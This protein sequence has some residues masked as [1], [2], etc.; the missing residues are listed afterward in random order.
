MICTNKEAQ[1]SLE[2]ENEQLKKRVDKLEER[3]DALMK[4]KKVD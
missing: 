1:S 2:R 4:N 3:I